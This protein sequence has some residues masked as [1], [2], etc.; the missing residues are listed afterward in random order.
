LLVFETYN[1][2]P[3]MGK[4][5]VRQKRLVDFKFCILVLLICIWWR[6]NLYTYES[7]F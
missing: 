7:C 4:S 6:S 2:L 1:I 3:L 5:N